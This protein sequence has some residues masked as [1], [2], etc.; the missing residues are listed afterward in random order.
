MTQ[1][2]IHG[3]AHAFGRDEIFSGIDFNLAAGEVVALVGPSGCGKTTLLHLC[4]GLLDVQQGRID[5]G[6][7]NPASMFQQP[8]LLPWKTT[9]DNIALGLKAAG[10]ARQQRLQ[11]ASSLAL[12]LGLA[13]GDL[14]KFPHQL[15][16][17]M[18]S[19]VSLARALVLQPDLLLL[20]EPF[21]ALDIG[22]KEDLYAL[23]LAE[24]A[25]R[26]M[27]VLMITH[28]LMEA[29]R[30]AD[31]ILVMA[32]APGRIVSHLELDLPAVQRSDAWIYQH[33]AELLQLPAV[34]ESFGLATRAPQTLPNAAKVAIREA[35]PLP[36]ASRARSR[37]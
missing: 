14:G 35:A 34:R 26:G 11:Q 30:L 3:L 6:F 1:L 5:N 10:M 7:G 33:T 24:Q 22:L 16:G 8:R 27:G 17:G 4:A 36:L 2:H 28:D 37:C 25:A 21:A 31:R 29:V 23:L 9:L 18:Q 15:S 13:A 12:R 20:D 32:A 19:R